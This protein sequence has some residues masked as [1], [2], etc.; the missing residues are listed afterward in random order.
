MACLS[1]N[2]DSADSLLGCNS[3]CD[4]K[5]L[6]AQHPDVNFKKVFFLIFSGLRTIDTD[7]CP[8]GDPQYPCKKKQYEDE[9][10]YWDNMA[11]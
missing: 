2:N 7:N 9:N 10:N 3:K 8:N 6:L 1:C 5:F 4:I 11:P